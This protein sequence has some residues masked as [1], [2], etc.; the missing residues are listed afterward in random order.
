MGRALLGHSWRRPLFD[1]ASVLVHRS[2]L[3]GLVNC[4][5]RMLRMESVV[6]IP[7][8]T[9]LPLMQQASGSARWSWL[10]FVDRRRSQNE[11]EGSTDGQEAKRYSE[12]F[13]REA[14]RQG[15]GLR[16]FPG[17]PSP[18][19]QECNRFGP[20]FGGPGRIHLMRG[21]GPPMKLPGAGTGE[22]SFQAEE[23]E[24]ADFKVLRVSWSASSVLSFL[25]FGTTRRRQLKSSSLVESIEFELIPPP[26]IDARVL[27]HVQTVVDRGKPY[28]MYL[29]PGPVGLERVRKADGLLRALWVEDKRLYLVQGNGQRLALDHQKPVFRTAKTKATLLSRVARKSSLVEEAVEILAS[30]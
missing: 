29:T 6:T 11:A 18:P 26:I 25:V 24:G 7:C 9:R 10:D 5:K 12:E 19:F 16:L 27:R 15:N 21:S 1:G 30:G 17:F 2:A 14:V 28:L 8:P 23:L 3:T 13:K 4:G 20:P 22:G